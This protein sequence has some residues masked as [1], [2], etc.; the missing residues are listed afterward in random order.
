MD[1]NCLAPLNLIHR[2]WLALVG[3]N[4]YELI[5]NKQLVLR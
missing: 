1:V 4:V 5:S 2:V 3:N